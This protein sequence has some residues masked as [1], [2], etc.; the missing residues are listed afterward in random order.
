MCY[1]SV[2]QSLYFRISLSF[3]VTFL[4]PEIAASINVDVLFSLSW[5]MMSCIVRGFYN[6]V[7]LTSQLVPTNWELWYVDILVIVV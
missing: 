1:F 2:V 7:T 5:I 6:M 3:L 4:P